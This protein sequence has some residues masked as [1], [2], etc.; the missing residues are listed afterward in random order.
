MKKQMSITI[1][2]GK[3]ELEAIRN[4]ANNLKMNSSEYVRFCVNN[5]IQ[6]NYVPKTKI[7]QFLH[8]IY[9]DSELK[10]L[11]KLQKIVK[12]LEQSCL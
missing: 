3:E 7:V 6:E 10:K 8:K 5:A 12:E 11:G 2:V 9:T 1:R 4:K